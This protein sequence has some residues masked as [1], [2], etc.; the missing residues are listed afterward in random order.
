MNELL[1]LKDNT[2]RYNIATTPV[3]LSV[4]LFFFQFA[5]TV[6]LATLGDIGFHLVKVTT[7]N[8]LSQMTM[9]LFTQFLGTHYRIDNAF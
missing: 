4:N 2:L 6:I 5:R 8:Q 9:C 1:F 3:L 7:Q